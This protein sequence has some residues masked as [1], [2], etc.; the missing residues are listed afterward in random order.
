MVYKEIIA[1]KRN[2]Q[3]FHVQIKM[4]QRKSTKKICLRPQFKEDTKTLDWFNP[5]GWRHSMDQNIVYSENE[6]HLNF[7]YI[8]IILAC[9]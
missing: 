4:S 7:F 2:H 5:W 1:T 3:S 9:T 8:Q 6:Q